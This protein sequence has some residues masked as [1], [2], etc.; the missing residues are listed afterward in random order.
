MGPCGSEKQNLNAKQTIEMKCDVKKALLAGT[1]SPARAK[2]EKKHVDAAVLISG[3][4]HLAR[5]AQR[6]RESHHRRHGDLLASLVQYDCHGPACEKSR[7]KYIFNTQ[8]NRVYTWVVTLHA[9]EERWCAD[10]VVWVCVSGILRGCVRRVRVYACWT[11]CVGGC[12]STHAGR[13]V[14]VIHYEYL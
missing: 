8:T 10:T 12:A 13:G 9:V 11:G 6:F 1:Q 7:A 5:A 3:T 2:S 4:P 14:W